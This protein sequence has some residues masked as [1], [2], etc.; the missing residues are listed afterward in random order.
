[1]EIGAIFADATGANNKNKNAGEYLPHQEKHLALAVAEASARAA[2]D[3]IKGQWEYL[4]ERLDFSAW[5]FNHSLS[6]QVPEWAEK[7]SYANLLVNGAE[8]GYIG[9][10]NREICASL[11]LKKSVAILEISFAKLFSLFQ[12]LPA[13]TYAKPNKYPAVERDLAFALDAKILYGDIKTEIEKFNPLIKKVELFDV[14]EGGKLDAGLKSL[15]FHINYESAEKTLAASEVDE[16]QNN[17]IKH[18]EEKFE[19]KIRNF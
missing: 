1:L 12:S 19:A 7:N 15:A 3:K 2:Y 14:Y 17:L 8:L 6:G 13:K 9:L 18:L 11:G 16:L 5:S 10:I 4:L